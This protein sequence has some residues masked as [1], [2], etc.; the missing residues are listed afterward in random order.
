MEQLTAMELVQMQTILQ[1]HCIK[2]DEF[3][4]QCEKYN[5]NPEFWIKQKNDIIT[6]M[7]KIQNNYNNNYN[8]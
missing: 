3:I 2:C 4:A 1:M 8:Q 6:G 5:N 7:K